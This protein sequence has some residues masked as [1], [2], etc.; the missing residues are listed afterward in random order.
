MNVRIIR[1][2]GMSVFKEIQRR[3]LSCVPL[4][5]VMCVLGNKCDLKAQ[6]C[7]P[8]HPAQEYATSVGARHFETSALSEEG[9]P[10]YNTKISGRMCNDVMK[11]LMIEGGRG[12]WWL[13]S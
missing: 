9:A 6:R 5:A 1:N 11:W 8:L 13:E 12:E 7:V 2:F 3:R 4:L 10:I